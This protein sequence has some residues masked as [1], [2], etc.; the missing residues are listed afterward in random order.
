MFCDVI[1]LGERW[2][3]PN[4]HKVSFFKMVAK[5]RTFKKRVFRK[6][7]PFGSIIPF[8]RG[9]ELKFVDTTIGLTVS[10]TPQVNLINAVAVGT[11]SINRIGKHVSGRFLEFRLSL[12]SLGVV[13]AHVPDNV[14]IAIV[15]DR[16]CVGALPAFGEVFTGVT[17]AGVATNNVH[18]PRNAGNVERFQ[19][20]YDKQSMTNPQNFVLPGIDSSDAPYN[21][22]GRIALKG[23]ETTFVTAAGGIADISG[24]SLMVFVISG[25]NA[26]A[27]AAYQLNG[28][29]RYGFTDQ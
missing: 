5:K 1:D 9:P 15:Y 11:D 12:Q 17:A 28:T 16:Q 13:A 21:W 6:K 18:S 26:L 14:R 10:T 29:F 24:G 23:L 3:S 19:V 7:S 8:R 4:F 27:A 25:Y 22:K 2:G 20:L